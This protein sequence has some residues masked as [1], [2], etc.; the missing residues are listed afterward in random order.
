MNIKTIEYAMKQLKIT[1]ENDNDDVTFHQ[2]KQTNGELHIYAE[3]RCGKNL[4]LSD[5]EIYHQAEEYLRHHME[6]VI[7]QR[8]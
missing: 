1:I 8:D 7:H 5:E 2:I 6:Y 4:G 3:F